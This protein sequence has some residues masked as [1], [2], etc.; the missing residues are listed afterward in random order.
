MFFCK[1]F[2]RNN[3]CLSCASHQFLWVCYS[4]DLDEVTPS[5]Q[6]CRLLDD[7]FPLNL[8]II[9]E[10]VLLVNMFCLLPV[11]LCEMCVCKVRRLTLLMVVGVLLGTNS[12]WHWFC[13][14]MSASPLH[15]K[16]SPMLC[17]DWEQQLWAHFLKLVLDVEVGMGSS[18]PIEI[19]E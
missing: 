6:C 13:G 7:E 14:P 17:P 4:I 2:V 3:L 19:S 10:T 8:A 16:P 12:C 15:T 5:L 18:K 11:S 1:G 9:V